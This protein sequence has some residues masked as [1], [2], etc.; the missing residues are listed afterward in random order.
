MILVYGFYFFKHCGKGV[1][2]LHDEIS[3]HFAVYFDIV[4]FEFVDERTIVHAVLFDG[5]GNA[6]NPEPPKL[7]FSK[8]PSVIGVFAGMEVGFRGHPCQS[9]FGHPI[10]FIGSEE[11][12]MFGVRGNSPFYS[13][14]QLCLHISLYYPCES[15]IC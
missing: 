7:S 6:R 12:F 1:G 13:H 8:F 4:G 5:F 3:E 2:V 10:P 11:L 9:P 14:S 15:G